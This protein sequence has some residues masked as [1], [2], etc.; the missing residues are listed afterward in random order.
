MLIGVFVIYQKY[1]SKEKPPV[2]EIRQSPF[3]NPDKKIQY[4]THCIGAAGRYVFPVGKWL[5]IA[6]DAMIRIDPETP[7][8]Q[9]PPARPTPLLEDSPHKLGRTRLT[10]A[11]F[12]RHNT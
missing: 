6:G 9:T 4:T 1:Q 11:A 7:A 12:C 5:H 10:A 3:Q 8:E 2:V